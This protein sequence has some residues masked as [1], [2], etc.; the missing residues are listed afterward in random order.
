[1]WK[2]LVALVLLLL[3]VASL[4]G[5]RLT[6]LIA[7]NNPNDLLVANNQGIELGEYCYADI[8]DDGVEELINIT[9]YSS[10]VCITRIDVYRNNQ[11]IASAK[12]LNS[13]FGYMDLTL[14]KVDEHTVKLLGHWEV[15]DGFVY[16]TDFGKLT[17]QQEDRQWVLK[18]EIDPQDAIKTGPI[19]AQA[20]Y[21]KE[22]METQDDQGDE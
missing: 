8:D 16:T 19:E 15:G 14:E 3:L 21:I 7:A 22:R 17:M 4:T 5:N 2:K 11:W 9:W 20:A 6:T 18:S 13:L 10:G 1:M 12:S